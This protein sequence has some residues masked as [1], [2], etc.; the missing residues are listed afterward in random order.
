MKTPDTKNHSEESASVTL[1][2]LA[3]FMDCKAFSLN[4]LSS[5]SP[6]FPWPSLPE[7][8]CNPEKKKS[9]NLQKEDL[10]HM[11]TTST[12]ISLCRVTVVFTFNEFIACLSHSHTMT[13]FD[14]PGKHAF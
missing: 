14:T 6:S 1:S 10:M 4:D 11:Q 12:Y 8:S 7:S 3:R 13:P 2:F 5:S 9:Y